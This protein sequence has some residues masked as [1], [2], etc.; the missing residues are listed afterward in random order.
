[1]VE[2]VAEVDKGGEGVGPWSKTKVELTDDDD[3]SSAVCGT[4][5]VAT[6]VCI[7]LVP[8]TVWF[9]HVDSGGCLSVNETDLFTASDIIGQDIAMV[10]T[11]SMRMTRLRLRRPELISTVAKGRMV[12]V[13]VLP[14]LAWDTPTL[15]E[16]SEMAGVARAKAAMRRLKQAV[17]V[18]RNMLSLSSN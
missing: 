4:D 16:G 10:A 18:N 7:E 6:F 3:E 8:R 15:V 11:G 9:D 17:R 13:K 5:L 1:M 12:D 14:K 2:F